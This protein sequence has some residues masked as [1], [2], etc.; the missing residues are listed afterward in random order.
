MAKQSDT[1]YVITRKARRAKVTVPVCWQPTRKDAEIFVKLLRD[2]PANSNKTFGIRP[3]VRG[4]IYVS[5]DS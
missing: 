1:V 5:F 3:L 4:K 2:D